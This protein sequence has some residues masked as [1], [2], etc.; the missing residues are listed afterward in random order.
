MLFLAAFVAFFAVLHL[1]F[2]RK[3]KAWNT[4]R[5]RVAWGAGLAFFATGGWALLSPE[6]LMAKLPSLLSD[7]PEIVYAGAG[8]QLL[9]GLG[10]ASKKGRKLSSWALLSGLAMMLPANQ[11]AALHGSSVAAVEDQGLWL[12][13]PIQLL[14][15]FF[16]WRIG[17]KPK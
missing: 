8:T 13:L 7:F 12:S 10:L 6:H 16:V 3:R 15:M 11:Q 5:E 9:A 1:Q 2:F 17:R 14:L 4:F